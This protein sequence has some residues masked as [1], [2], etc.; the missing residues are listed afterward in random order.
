MYLLKLAFPK[1][2]AWEIV[3]DLGQE[4]LLHFLDMNK[5]EQPFKLPY[6]EMIKRCEE[7]ERKIQ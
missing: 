3:N 2:H 7:V 6:T 1:D 5:E 4:S